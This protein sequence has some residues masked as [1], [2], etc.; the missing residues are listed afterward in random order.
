MHGHLSL[1]QLIHNRLL[2]GRDLFGKR[3]GDP[4][5]EFNSSLIDIESRSLC[6]T[7]VFNHGLLSA[8]TNYH[9]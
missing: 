9:E 7:T 1:L 2:L 5:V 4:F 3:C 8:W 6:F